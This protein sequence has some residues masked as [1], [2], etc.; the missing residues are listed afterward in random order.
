MLRNATLGHPRQATAILLSPEE[1]ETLERWV[2]S[3]KTER[4]LL[5]RARIILYAAGGERTDAIAARLDT[6]PSRVSKWRTRF[7]AGRLAALSDRPRSGAPGQYGDQTRKRIL[8]LLD[9]PPPDGHATWSGELLAAALGGVSKHQVWRVLRTHQISL[10]RRRGW[11]VSTDPELARKAADIVGLYLDPPE[12]AVVLSVDEKP[13]IQALE[14]AQG[15]LRLPGGKALTG[16][17]HGYSRHGATTL[18]AALEVATGQVVAGHY[19]RAAGR[20]AVTS[21]SGVR[22]NTG[23]RS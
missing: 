11:C 18:F 5:E 19:W 16:F 4:R 14:R 12:N 21:H 20:V 1:R 7:A 8:A 23:K 9:E 10:R 15:W 17:S 13:R 6:T 22:R 3:H 2:R